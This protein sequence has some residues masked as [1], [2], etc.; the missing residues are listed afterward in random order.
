MTVYVIRFDVLTFDILTRETVFL[1]VGGLSYWKETFRLSPSLFPLFFARSL[2]HLSL[3]FLARLHWREPGTSYITP[4][5]VALK[6][7][8]GWQG[9]DPWTKSCYQRILLIILSFYKS[10]HGKYQLALNRYN[11]IFRHFFAL[12]GEN[13]PP[14][15]R[16]KL[17]DSHFHQSLKST[18]ATKNQNILQEDY[19]L[20]DIKSNNSF[21]WN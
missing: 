4:H 15:Q 14:H 12:P 6:R 5:G 7:Y 1:E 17:S 18:K 21:N 10:V 19:M 3:A 8:F 9:P 20:Q 16:S 13:S 2:F 11:N